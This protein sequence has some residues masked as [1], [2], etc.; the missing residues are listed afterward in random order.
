MQIESTHFSVTIELLTSVCLPD[1]PSGSAIT[2]YKDHFYVIGDDANTILVLDTHYNAVHSIPVFNFKSNRIAKTDKP[3]FETSIIIHADDKDYLL[4]LGSASRPNREKGLLIDLADHS[5]KTHKHLNLSEFAT[6]LKT[7][8]IGEINIEGSTVINNILMLSNR[9]NHSNP[10][11]SLI[12]TSPDFWKN[13]QGARISLLTLDASCTAKTILGVS[14]LCYVKEKDILLLT[15]TSELTS[16]AY[17]DGIIGDSYIGR[18]D[19]ISQKLN[20][21]SFLLDGIINL[22]DADK[23]FVG[24]KIEGISVERIEDNA[25]LIHLVSDNDQ[26][27]SRLFKIK[28]K[29]E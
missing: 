12:L 14:E 5:P 28:M 1:F 9:G 20:T 8:V 22:V 6:R 27:Q 4:I 2:Q 3:D 29:L 13:Q 26:G 10:V 16:N 19:R 7:C 24:E 18:I 25:L 21:P 11:N 17:D 15:L 23:E